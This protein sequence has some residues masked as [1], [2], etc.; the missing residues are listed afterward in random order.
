MPLN[1]TLSMRPLAFTL[2]IE[3]LESSVLVISYFI[4]SNPQLLSMT[5][6][7]P[8]YDLAGLISSIFVKFVICASEI[9]LFTN[10]ISPGSLSFFFVANVPTLKFSKFFTTP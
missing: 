4:I 3:P 10:T 2:N 5:T 7:F 9:C 6:C 1:W 8:V